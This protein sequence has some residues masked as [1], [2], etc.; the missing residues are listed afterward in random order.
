MNIP[1][2]YYYKYYIFFIKIEIY[3]FLFETWLCV[4][5]ISN[6]T[7]TVLSHTVF[8]NFNKNKKKN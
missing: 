5:Q 6:D 4:I 3:A 7:C 1:M 2:K 8:I